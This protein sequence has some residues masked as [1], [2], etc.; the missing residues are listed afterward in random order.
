M[1]STAYEAKAFPKLIR[2]NDPNQLG[3]TPDLNVTPTTS[4]MQTDT[5]IGGTATARQRR[6]PAVA[7]ISTV[8]PQVPSRHFIAMATWEGAVLELLGSYFVAEVRDLA[9]EELATAEFDL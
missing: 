7:R 9:S 5:M 6:R 2:M 1:T 4:G 3:A 8:E